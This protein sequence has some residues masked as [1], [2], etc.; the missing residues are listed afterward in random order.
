MLLGAERLWQDDAVARG[1]RP[2]M[3]DEG[4]ISIGGGCHLPAARQRGIS[5]VFRAMRSSRT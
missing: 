3:A 2:G 4:R 5:M 1:C